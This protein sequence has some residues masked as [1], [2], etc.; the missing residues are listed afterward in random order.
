[1]TAPFL[2]KECV[3]V[4]SIKVDLSEALK[5]VERIRKRIDRAMTLAVREVTLGI[6]VPAVRQAVSF[7]GEHAPIGRLGTRTGQLLSQVAPKFYR[8]KDGTPGGSVRV[9]GTRAFIAAFHEK[10][11]QSHGRYGVSK[12]GKTRAQLRKSAARK[13][14]S[15]LPARRMLA[16]AFA[17]IKTQMEIALKASFEKHFNQG[18]Q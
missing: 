5:E 13:G 18:N 11:T 3:K 4:V 8:L 10:G 7:T 6:A 15:A 12:T 2:F 16:T 14:T 9:R 1:M 17:Q